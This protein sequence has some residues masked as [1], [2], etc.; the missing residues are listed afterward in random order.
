[1][2]AHISGFGQ[3]GPYRDRAAFG[4]IGE[5]IGGLRH[6]CNHP[7]GTTDLPPVRVGISIG[8]SLAGLYAAFGIAAACWQRDRP[9]GDRKGR[10]LDVALTDSVLSMMEGMLPEYGVFGSVRQPTGS[11]IPT[12]APSSAYPCSDG[13]WV[14]VAANSEPLFAKLAALMGQPDLPRDPRF[15]NNP[16]RVK[17]VEE[18]DRIIGNWT[19]GLTAEEADRRLTEADIPC[20]LIYTAAEIAA[21]PQFRERGMVRDVEDPQFGK[22]LHPGVV[23]H[24]PD[25]PG[26]IR[27]PGPPLG[28]HNDEILGEVLGMKPRRSK[29]FGRKVS[30]DA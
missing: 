12:A 25:D 14:L 17:N 28:A 24:V 18:L 29:R 4:V 1:M 13:K 27:W 19:K 7:P 11:R 9:N 8:D 10:T 2:I 15:A 6:L 26:A 22:V 23:P 30:Y 5:A 3:D 16:S 21:D 20:T